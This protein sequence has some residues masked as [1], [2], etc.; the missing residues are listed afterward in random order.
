M[1]LSAYYSGKHK[2]KYK[3]NKKA[4]LYLKKFREI[5]QHEVILFNNKQIIGYYH[6]LLHLPVNRIFHMGFLV[7]GGVLIDPF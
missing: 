3:G 7:V 6:K 5:F 4:G 2:T 1:G